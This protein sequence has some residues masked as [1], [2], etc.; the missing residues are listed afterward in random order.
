M[1]DAGDVAHTL[2]QLRR[3]DSTKAAATR[4]IATAPSL[5]ARLL[6]SMAAMRRADGGELVVAMSLSPARKSCVPVAGICL[7]CCCHARSQA[8]D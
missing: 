6:S 3:D 1:E 5:S 8:W 7:M 2:L 4:H